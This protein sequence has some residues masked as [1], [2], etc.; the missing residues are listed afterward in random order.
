M[1]FQKKQEGNNKKLRTEVRSFLA[2][3]F[4]F[5]DADAGL[6]LL[7]LFELN[8]AVFQSKQSVVGAFAHVDTGM[9]LGASLA[10]ENVT[11]ENELTVSTFYAESSGF[12]VT[13]VFSRAY[14]FL[15]SHSY[16]TS[17]L[18]IDCG[19]D[20]LGVRLSV[21]DASAISFLCFVLEDTDLL[22]FAV[23]FQ[24]GFD[25]GTIDVGSSGFDLAVIGHEQN[26]VELYGFTGFNIQLLDEQ[27]IAHGSLVLFSA[28]FKH[29]VHFQTS[30]Y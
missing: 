8:L 30:F 19:D 15:M 25:D 21:T 16:C 20:D 1:K 22:A 23:L 4:D 13:T 10:N 17:R 29:C 9:D 7:E 3:L 28:C 27:S 14:T 24:F 6:V 18:C 2:L 5:K 26:L 11:G 12:G